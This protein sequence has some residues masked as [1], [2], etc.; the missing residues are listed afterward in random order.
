MTFI[1]GGYIINIKPIAIGIFVVP[2]L[3]EFKM[4][5]KVGIKYPIPTLIAIATNI[6]K[7][8]FL[9]RKFNFFWPFLYIGLRENVK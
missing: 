8:R 7:V 9:S 3:N 1:K 2:L 5:G 6:H 4:S